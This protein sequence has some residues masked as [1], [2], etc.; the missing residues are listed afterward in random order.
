[1]ITID[2]FQ[3]RYRQDVIALVL[4]FQND[5]SRPPVTVDDQPNLLRLI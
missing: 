4:H 1:M 3:E 5:G 2:P